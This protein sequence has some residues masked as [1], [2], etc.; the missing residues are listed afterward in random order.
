MTSTVF[1]LVVLLVILGGIGLLITRLWKR[2]PD[3]PDQEGVDILP[4]LILAIAVGVATFSLARLAR[5]GLAGDRLA[6]ENTNEIAA[7]LAGLV[8]AS[9]ISFFLWRRQQRRR[10][11]H[12]QLAGWP[13]YLALIEV[14][15]LT[16]FFSSVTTVALD[17]FGEG[18]GPDLWT[19]LIVYGG[20]VAFHWWTALRE[21]PAGDASELPRL[22]GS[23]AALIALSVG[24]VGVL[25]WL[26]G[27]GYGTVLDTS[28]GQDADSNAVA[29]SLGLLIAGAPIWAWRWL[30]AWD[31]EPS[32]LR[33][34]YLAAVSVLALA[35]TIGAG[36][37]LVAVGLSYLLTST[38][39]AA[40]HFESLPT[41]LSI[42]LVALVIW[43]HHRRRM[44]EGRNRAIIGY[45]YSM[46]A[47][48][49]GTL[50]GAGTILVTTVWDTPLAGDPTRQGLIG[51]GVTVLATGAVWNYFWRG[52]QR[53][54]T[55]EVR[56][57][58]RRVYLIG[59]AFV[60]GLTAAGALIAVLVVAF[61]KLL[62]EGDQSTSSLPTS[63]S[64][65]V[66]A[67]IAIWHLFTVIRTDGPR[68]TTPLGAPF[69]VTVICSHPGPL[70]TVFPK[71]A[72]IR[73]H[74]RTDGV[75][76]VDEAMARQIVEGVGGRP[77]Y[78][79]VDQDGFRTAPVR[80]D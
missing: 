12:P 6:G 78:V 52:A 18:G 27:Q 22:V 15:F 48:G 61:R 51:L 44:G 11:L 58:Q 3:Q 31:E 71:E 39:D 50:V 53:H 19:N 21:P 32:V 69:A 5:A 47:I 23:G 67:G 2:H 36:I 64:L 9:P 17:L 25:H 65:T 57:L 40:R 75:G 73:V 4:Y 7:A 45:G 62:G 55:E 37:A 38:V 8:V 54:R 33:S 24:L 35:T 79:W 14:V 29:A 20:V 46:A 49:L 60:L 43:V 16:S 42:L 56:T 70:A 63:I 10:K 74:Y 66:L 59:M 13:V 68:D 26:L 77:S 76:V 28:L 30:P 1:A 72:R 41:T 34:V 80:G